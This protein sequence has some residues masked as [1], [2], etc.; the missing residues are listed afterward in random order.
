VSG[1]G[2][3]R[4]IGID[5]HI[6]STPLTCSHLVQSV[7]KL[8]VYALCHELSPSA[9]KAFEAAE[10]KESNEE[11]E[12]EKKG[13]GQAATANGGGGGR[14]KLLP[15]WAAPSGAAATTRF[16]AFLHVCLCVWKALGEGERGGLGTM[17]GGGR[18]T[19]THTHTHTPQPTIQSINRSI[20]S[21]TRLPLP[22]YLHPPTGPPRRRVDR[23]LIEYITLRF[24]SVT[25]RME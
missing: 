3:L 5:T 12:K 14:G 15:P 11:E 4:S 20:L 2:L 13:K 18:Y 9:I 7:V 21:L 23:F 10:E 25:R 24:I 17:I 16:G 19:H 22:P 1:S 8:L 6:A